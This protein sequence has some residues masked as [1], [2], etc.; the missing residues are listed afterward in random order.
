MTKVAKKSFITKFVFKLLNDQH[1]SKG[2]SSVDFDYLLGLVK[3]FWLL[4]YSIEYCVAEVGNTDWRVY[5]VFNFQL[6]GIF[7]FAPG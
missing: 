5:V 4:L 3:Q 1:R 7:H 2:E 6:F